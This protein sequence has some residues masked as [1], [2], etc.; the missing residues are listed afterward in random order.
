MTTDTDCRDLFHQPVLLRFRDRSITEIRSAREA[1]D[2][3]RS[4]WP[5]TRGKWYYAADR[6]CVSALEGK[7]SV[8][9][10]RRIFVEAVQE[11]RLD[12]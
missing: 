10:A 3:L 4:T 6:A 7:T 1:H 9:I 5:D 12:A 11:S 8:H 2:A